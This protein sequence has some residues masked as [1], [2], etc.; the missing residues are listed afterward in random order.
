MALSGKKALVIL[1]PVEFDYQAYDVIRDSLRRKGITVSVAGVEP[2]GA[3]SNKGFGVKVD[4]LVKDAKSYDYDAFVMVGGKGY[5]YLEDNPDVLKL[6]KDAKSKAQMVM[7][8]SLAP[9]ARAEVTK[10]KLVTGPLSLARLLADKAK[11]YTADSVTVD[12][13]LVT[14]ADPT[15]APQAVTRLVSVLD[16]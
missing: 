3:K 12:E 10:D 5:L 4:K 11:A 1:P 6:L 9:A 14:A 15:S 13:K 8:E 16:S 2:G 7:G